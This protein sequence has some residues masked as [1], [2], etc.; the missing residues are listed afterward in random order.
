MAYGY[1]GIPEDGKKIDSRAMITFLNGDMI[2][3]LVAVLMQLAGIEVEHSCLDGQANIELKLQGGIVVPGHPDGILPVQPGVKQ[4]TLLEVKSASDYAFRNHFSKGHIDDGYMLQHQTYL[5]ALKLK[6]GVFVAISKNA[7]ELVEV[8]TEY[9]PDFAKWAAR[10]HLTAAHST[11]DKLPPRYSDGDAYG[12][13]P[14]KKQKGRYRLGALCTYCAWRD[15][16]WPGLEMELRS[17]KPTYLITEM[18]T[19]NE[20]EE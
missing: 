19:D 14:D 5:R 3:T 9:D 8:W 7:G 4:R 15:T 2:E 10:N 13:I 11:P 12:A 1:H 6:H 17:G 20:S 18:P 16:C